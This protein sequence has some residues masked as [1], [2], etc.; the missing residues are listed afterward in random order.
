MANSRILTGTI[1]ADLEPY[2]L[3]TAEILDGDP[4]PSGQI[5]CRIEQEGSRLVAGVFAC[6]PGTI[7]SR[8]L[9]H[10]TIHVLEGEVRIVLDSGDVVDL[11]AG[12]VAVLPQGETVT[13][14]YKSS[15]REFFVLSC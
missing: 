1:H 13:W 14:I 10:E 3:G 15:F 2:G 6:Q 11:G 4:R 9:S 8:L 5:F 12:D 7:R